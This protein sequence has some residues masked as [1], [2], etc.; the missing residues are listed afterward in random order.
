MEL[1]GTTTNVE[2][3]EMIIYEDLPKAWMIAT[4]HYYREFS[5]FVAEMCVPS[6]YINDHLPRVCDFVICVICCKS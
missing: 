3:E 6:L 1:T 2:R 4:C 5:S